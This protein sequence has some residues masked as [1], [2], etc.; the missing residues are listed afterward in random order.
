MAAYDQTLPKMLMEGGIKMRETFWQI[1][2]HNAF[3]ASLQ[4]VLYFKDR[5]NIRV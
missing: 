5:P 2:P 3:S 1:M 4:G